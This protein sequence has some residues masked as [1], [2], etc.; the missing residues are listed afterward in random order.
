[1]PQ[2]HSHRV[3]MLAFK[4]RDFGGWLLTGSC[5]SS[6]ARGGGPPKVVEGHGR[7]RVT[8]RA[9]ETPRVPLHPSSH[10]PPPPRGRIV[11]TPTTTKTLRLTT[12]PPN[13]P[14]SAQPN[15]GL[16]GKR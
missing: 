6:P 14:A 4:A 15:T 7:S 1:M 2:S 8:D 16:F 10:G 13:T 3:P 12:A 5:R 9:Q 11:I